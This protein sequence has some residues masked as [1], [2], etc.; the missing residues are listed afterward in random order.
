[1]WVK[2]CS[3]LQDGFSSKGNKYYDLV[4]GIAKGRRLAGKAINDLQEK[5]EACHGNCMQVLEEVK[6]LPESA[7]VA[8]QQEARI[9]EARAQAVQFML[10]EPEQKFQEILQ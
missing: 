4:A 8:L 3:S 5:L 7:K 9:A 10:S 6:S 1:M 2:A